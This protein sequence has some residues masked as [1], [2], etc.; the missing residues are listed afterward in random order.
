MIADLVLILAGPAVALALVAGIVIGRRSNVQRQLDARLAHEL[1]PT[2][3]FA[4]RCGRPSECDLQAWECQ[5]VPDERG[6]S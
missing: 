2:P 3:I 1:A 5:L 6:R 4:H